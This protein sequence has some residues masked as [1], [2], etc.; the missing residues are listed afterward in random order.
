MKIVYDNII[1]SIQKSGG[2]SVVW[3]ELTKRLLEEKGVTTEFIEYTNCSTN[4]FRKKLGI[5][6]ANKKI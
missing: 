2:I 1:Y 3:Y 5:A 4:I 6:S